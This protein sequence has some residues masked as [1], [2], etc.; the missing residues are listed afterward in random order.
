[1]LGM[2]TPANL[3]LHRIEFCDCQS[4]SVF[5]LKILY[6]EKAWHTLH[7]IEHA[8]LKFFQFSQVSIFTNTDAKNRN[9]HTSSVAL[10]HAIVRRNPSS[11]GVVAR[12][13]NRRSARPTSR[14]RRGCPL[15]LLVSHTI[16]PEK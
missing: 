16:S 4:F 1:M 14:R 9:D 12:K 10:Y 13:P 15:G 6:S 2:I 5:C 7:D 8:L 11:K 3:I